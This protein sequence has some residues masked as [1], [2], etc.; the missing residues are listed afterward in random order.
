MAEKLEHV[1]EVLSWV[2]TFVQGVNAIGQCMDGSHKLAEFQRNPNS[3]TAEAWATGVG[4]VFEG[5]G[6]TVGAIPGFPFCEFLERLYSR[7]PRRSLEASSLYRTHTIPGSMRRQ[8]T[9]AP[10][11]ERSYN[12]ARRKTIRSI[13]RLLSS[14]T[15]IFVRN[16]SRE[17]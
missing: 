12:R 2:N 13:S 10:G 7:L 4:R 5:F 1:G 14:R 16:V 17:Y 9:T 3:K 15:S 6:D 11:R 8:K